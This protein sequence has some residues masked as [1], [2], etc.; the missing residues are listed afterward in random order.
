M[1]KNVHS[2][3]ITFADIKSLR[4]GQENNQKYNML[5]LK[6]ELSQKNVEAGYKMSK[7]K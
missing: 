4:K 7:L 6:I 3:K 1:K 2:D 5:V